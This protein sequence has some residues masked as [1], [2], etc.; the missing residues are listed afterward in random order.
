MNPYSIPSLICLFAMPLLGAFIYSRNRQSQ[1]NRLFFLLTVTI[2][3]WAFTEFNLRQAESYTTALFWTRAGCFKVMLSPLLIHFILAYI[4][5]WREY[6]KLKAVCFIYFPV[7]G[8]GAVDLFTGSI[9]GFPIKGAWGW[10]IGEPVYPALFIFYLAW[11]TTAIA[12]V[13]KETKSFLKKAK[14]HEKKSF[15]LFFYG[16]IVAIILGVAL[17]AIR[18]GFPDMSIAA[19]LL[20]SLYLG[21]VIWKYDLFLSPSDTADDIINLMGDG[22][23]LAG[24]RNRIVRVNRALLKLTGYHEKEI[25]GENISRLISDA[26]LPVTHGEKNETIDSREGRLVSRSGRSIPVLLSQ[27]TVYNKGNM[28]LALVIVAKDLTF[29][30]KAREE[31]A[32]AEKLESYEFIIR[33]IVHDFNNLLASISAHLFVADKLETLPESTRNN[34]EN[35]EKAAYVAANLTRRLGLYAKANAL[36]KSVCTIREIIN[37]SAELV[38]K[39]TS[40]RFELI[41]GSY[42]WPVNVDRYRMVQVF[43]NL[44]INARQAMCDEAGMITVR[45][46]NHRNDAGKDF[47]KITVCDEGEGIPVGIADKVFEP[48][49]TT[50]PQGTGLGLSIVKNIVESHGGTVTVVSRRNTGTTFIILLPKAKSIE[51]TSIPVYACGEKMHS[52]RILLMDADDSFRSIFSTIL[53]RFG[54]TVEQVKTGSEAIERIISAK[55]EGASFDCAILDLIVPAGI[56]ALQAI[57]RIREIDPAIKTV[58]TSGHADHP[59]VGDYGRYGFD[60]VLKKPFSFTDV[61]IALSSLFGEKVG[62]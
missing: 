45:C 14:P 25:I 38:L 44:F 18:T 32:R 60:A 19:A 47:V 40:I 56:G 58:L 26:S 20:F 41:S 15:R 24:T 54:L 46:D 17:G 3:Y 29:W 62:G 34:L 21:F 42:V 6:D 61:H 37:E 5:K 35:A 30:H 57:R 53:C 43:I 9:N 4:D 49:F 39:G 7:I 8:L 12:F 48:F 22:L 33:S 59:A 23:I 27:A 50:K 10:T 13:A 2:S 52:G 55:A 11:K 31:F 36:E 1:V 51:E 16:V 28:P